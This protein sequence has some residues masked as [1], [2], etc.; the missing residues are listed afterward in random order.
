MYGNVL[1]NEAR[2]AP[3]IE[4]GGDVM[5]DQPAAAMFDDPEQIG[6]LPSQVPNERRMNLGRVPLYTLEKPMDRLL[7]VGGIRRCHL[8]EIRLDFIELIFEHG[9]HE[10]RLAGE[11][12]VKG[13]LAHT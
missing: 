10:R 1:P 9:F 8:A 6:R 12:G 11:A 3:L 2:S 4:E 7:H 5:A 13:F